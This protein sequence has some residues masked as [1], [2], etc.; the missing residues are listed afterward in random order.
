AGFTRDYVALAL[1]G[2]KWLTRHGA[3][4]VGIDYL[5]IEAF[6]SPSHPVHRHLLEAG[7]VI[8]E[9]LDLSAVPPGHYELSCLPL[10]LPGA[11][12]A[13]ARVI[14]AEP[15]ASSPGSKVTR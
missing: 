5:S 2:A 13:P 15:S 9:G 12:G 11:D 10:L 14:L 1:D 6:D 3:R 4:L 8:V 7:I